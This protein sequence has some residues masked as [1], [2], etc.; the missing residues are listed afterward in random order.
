MF[1]VLWD[2]ESGNNLGDFDSEAEVLSMVREL[3]DANTPDYVD[4]LSVGR[5]DDDGVTTVVATG[6][7][8]S[9][10]AQGA[11]RLSTGLA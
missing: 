3:L 2:L 1:Y 11:E 5:T 6:A 7:E 10:R 4:M 8:L 9:A